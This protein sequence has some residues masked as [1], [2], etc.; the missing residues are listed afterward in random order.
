MSIC[1]S[2]T[3]DADAEEEVGLEIDLDEPYNISDN[4]S[5]T[6]VEELPRRY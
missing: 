2:T 1:Q 3:V 4:L 5:S 6:Q